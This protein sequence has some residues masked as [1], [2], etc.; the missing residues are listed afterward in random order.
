[1]DAGTMQHLGGKW[2]S[3]I[4][5]STC[6]TTD[7]PYAHPLPCLPAFLPAYPHPN[8]PHTSNLTPI[9]PCV[10]STTCTHAHVQS[11]PQAPFHPS[12]FPLASPQSLVLLSLWCSAALA[13]TPS[14]YSLMLIRLSCSLSLNTSCCSQAVT[15][16]VQSCVCPV[17]HTSA[18]KWPRTRPACIRVKN[19]YTGKVPLL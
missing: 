2:Y 10:F 16:S 12:A 11:N 18:V 6:R 8:V 17:T 15:C 1:M 9:I 3:I 13:H 19:E 5:F 4:H 7:T 14:W